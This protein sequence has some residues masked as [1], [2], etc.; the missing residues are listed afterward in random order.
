MSQ[1]VQIQR[2]EVF[3]REILRD[4]L[5]RFHQHLNGTTNLHIAPDAYDVRKRFLLTPLQKDRIRGAE[6]RPS[7]CA[8]PTPASA[9]KFRPYSHYKNEYAFAPSRGGC[10]GFDD[11]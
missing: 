9:P 6:E 4:R 1:T 2:F 5:Y 10:Q 8:K 11:D 3:L 7:G